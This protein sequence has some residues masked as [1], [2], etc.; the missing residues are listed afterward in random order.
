MYFQVQLDARGSRDNKTSVL[1][2]RT[3]GLPKGD[4]FVRRSFFISDLSFFGFSTRPAAS[5]E[6]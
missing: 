5:L 3:K 4:Q 1:N 2:C 6:E